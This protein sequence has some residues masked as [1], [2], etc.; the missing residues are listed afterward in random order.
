MHIA[1]AGELVTAVSAV[2]L[3]Q[4]TAAIALVIDVGEQ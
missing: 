1:L 2:E 3:N 4:D